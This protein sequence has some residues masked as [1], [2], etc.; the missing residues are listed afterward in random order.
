VRAHAED[1]FCRRKDER[2]IAVGVISFLNQL[3]RSFLNQL[4][5]NAIPK[6]LNPQ[7]GEAVHDWFH[8]A[9][10]YWLLD[11]RDELLAKE[12]VRRGWAELLLT[13]SEAGPLKETYRVKPECVE[14]IEAWMQDE[15][16]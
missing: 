14:Q 3:E 10:A 9:F 4:D 15:T 12:W 6:H 13:P 16:D 2:S 11:H 5:A 7:D 8:E 1:S